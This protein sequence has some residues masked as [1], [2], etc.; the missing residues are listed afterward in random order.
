MADNREK[1]WDIFLW[2]LEQ[3]NQI[4]KIA[5]SECYRIFASAQIVTNKGNTDSSMFA[6][7]IQGFLFY[8]ASMD[9]CSIAFR[10]HLDVRDVSDRWI[11][12]VLSTHDLSAS[13]SELDLITSYT[14]LIQ[15][16]SEAL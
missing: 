6:D 9:L 2:N 12:E 14:S 1:K 15:R 4:I 16:S 13:F 8:V 10:S 3:M 7:H 11:H 5:V